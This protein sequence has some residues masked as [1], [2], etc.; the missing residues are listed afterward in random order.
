M[1]LRLVHQQTPYPKR[2]PVEDVAMFIGTDMQLLDEDLSI[3]NAAP[4]VLHIDSSGPQALHL[5]TIQ[6]NPRFIGLFHKVLMAHL[7]VFTD[8]FE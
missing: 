1:D 2:V 7:A 4:A 3:F 6:L 8:G 5:G